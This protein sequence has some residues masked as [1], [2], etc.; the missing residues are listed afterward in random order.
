VRHLKTLDRLIADSSE[1]K[2]IEPAVRNILRLG[3]YQSVFCKGEI[4]EYA[5]LSESVELAKANH[6]RPVAGFVNAVLRKAQKNRLT[7]P[8]IEGLADTQAR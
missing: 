5:S 3:L 1:I 4:P 2:N 7:A 8:G 6:K